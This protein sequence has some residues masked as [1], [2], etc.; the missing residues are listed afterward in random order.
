VDHEGNT[1]PRASLGYECT[2]KDMTFRGHKHNSRDGCIKMLVAPTTFYFDALGPGS[3]RAKKAV[4]INEGDVDVEATLY[5]YPIASARIS[6]HYAVEGAVP[7]DR[8]GDPDFFL[9]GE[10]NRPLTPEPVLERCDDPGSF[11]VEIP[12][13]YYR[14]WVKPGGT[15]SFFLPVALRRMIRSGDDKAIR[16]P[17]RKGG[18]LTLTVLPSLDA[19]DWSPVDRLVLLRKN[20][21]GK[22]RKYGR[23]ARNEPSP[24]R[25]GLR[26]GNGMVPL[27]DYGETTMPDIRCSILEEGEYRLKMHRR[28]WNPGETDFRIVRREVAAVEL[29]LE[30]R[31][32]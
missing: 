8:I 19:G 29:R 16:I 31:E 26:S 1:V 30:R 23:F 3:L 28:G 2:W 11:S 25:K 14:I 15:E 20:E 5:F 13:D 6:F 17:L 12:P 21:H 24:S 10:C 7:A 22:W 4:T 9:Q 32:R 27:L 18:R